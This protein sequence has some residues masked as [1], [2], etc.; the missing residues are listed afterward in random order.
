MFVTPK[1]ITNAVTLA[2]PLLPSICEQIITP[3]LQGKAVDILTMSKYCPGDKFKI[4]DVKLVV[5]LEDGQLK[6]LNPPHVLPPQQSICKVKCGNFYFVIIGRKCYK[7][8]LDQGLWIS[9]GRFPFK[10]C[11]AKLSVIK[12][13]L[14]IYG[15]YRKK[16]KHCQLFMCYDGDN[17]KDFPVDYDWAKDYNPLKSPV[18]YNDEEA[19]IYDFDFAKSISLTSLEAKTILDCP[20][21]NNYIASV[22]H[23]NKLHLFSLSGDDDDNS[24]RYS[25]YDGKTWSTTKIDPIVFL[26]KM[27][28][29]IFS[30]GKL[31]YLLGMDRDMFQVFTFNPLNR[32]AALVNSFETEYFL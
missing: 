15:C 19:H 12:D 11:V 9:C 14:Y 29:N 10:I 3:Y 24:H 27:H 21:L 1:R 23:D 26:A 18:F 17:W 25:T 8:Y 20:D 22:M 7:F 30:D 31:I 5:L 6:D 28:D 16:S 4:D 32:E 2:T 13:K